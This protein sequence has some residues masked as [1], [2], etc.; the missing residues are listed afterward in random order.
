MRTRADAD[1]H[2]GAQAPAADTGG[3]SRQGRLL[4]LLEGGRSLPWSWIALLLTWIILRNLLEGVLERPGML[5]FDWREDVSLAMM[6]LHFPLFYL[7][8]FLLLSLW[9]HV[10]SGRPMA[11]VVR[12]VSLAY[13]VL[14]LAPVIDGIVSG[15]PGYD[16]RYLTG[17][18]GFLIHFWNPLRAIDEVS[19]GQRVEIALACLLAAWYA[20]IAL[21]S[22]EER[23]TPDA[24]AGAL[25]AGIPAVLLRAFGTALGVYVIS[26]VLGMWPA[27][28]ARLAAPWQPGEMSAYESVFRMGGLVSGESRRLAV[29]L[30]IPALAALPVFL[31]RLDP[32]L[33]SPVVRRLPW[34]RVLHYSAV[35]PLGCYL[36]YL[37]FRDYLPGLFAN[38]LDW[39]AAFTLWAA[40]V[41][42]VL[43]AIAWNDLHDTVADSINDPGRPLV[44]GI[45]QPRH[46]RMWA[47]ICCSIALYLAWIVSYPALL[48]MSACLLLSWLYSAPPLR[49]KRIPGVSTATLA[50]LTALSA[51]TGFAL[52][53]GEAVA[54]AFPRRVLWLLLAGITLGFTAKDLKDREGD[55]ATGVMTLA[56]LLPLPAARRWIALLVI[57]GYL[58]APALLPIGPAFTA[59][60]AL[61]ALAGAFMTLRLRRPDTPL[62]LVFMLFA[63]IMAAFLGGRADLLRDRL[64]DDPLTA[65]SAVIH[66]ERD[67]AR[68]HAMESAGLFAQTRR[69]GA[70]FRLASIPEGAANAERL[71]V[72]SA[73]L[74]PPPQALA[75][76]ARLVE[77]RP[78]RPVHWDLL[79]RS[80]MESDGPAAAVAVSRQALRRL[81]RPG[82][83]LANLAGLELKAAG[84]TPLAATYLSGAF[85]F[86]EDPGLL[87]VLWGDMRLFQSRPEAAANAYGSALDWSPNLP[88]AWAGL[89]Q[90]EHA[91]G[92]L[93]EALAAFDRANELDPEDP[94]IRNNRGVT[95]RDMGRLDDAFAAFREAHEKAPGLP[96]PVLNL[97]LTCEALGRPDEARYWFGMALRMRPG[98]TPAF[99]GLRRTESG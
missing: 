78:L 11:R 54:W 51:M 49:L 73:R 72:L 71:D 84:A 13:A 23:L 38:P 87:R 95:L 86:H 33:F 43:A 68:I 27:L 8:L 80:A 85:L 17:P 2:D 40:M 35:V 83:F 57:A 42:A 82:Q 7:T 16:L 46:A 41:S 53:T 18:G 52:V 74:A 36:G 65:H 69:E 56:T 30:S 76:S 32:G 79:F 4:S 93:P 60:A 67:V 29:S 19:P 50:A 97:G 24:P 10:T 75:A 6:V 22:R 45:L 14:L 66:L 48:L 12:A 3:H 59:I 1:T 92:R 91:R 70:A 55:A 58:L 94:W 99:Q 62:L 63:L 96:E 39:V 15:G 90:A 34:T 9:I 21:R 88:D 26:A 98:W 25:R 47:A 37:V 77:R 20:W 61:F 64:P 31:W 28:A 5:G 81:V 89:G 44:S